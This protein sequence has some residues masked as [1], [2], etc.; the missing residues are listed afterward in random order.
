MSKT[1]DESSPDM[2][3][4]DEYTG[5]MD[6]FSQATL[7]NLGLQPSFQEIFDFQGQDVIQSHAAFI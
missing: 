2:P 3:L 7:E 6:A 1:T 4:P 5:M